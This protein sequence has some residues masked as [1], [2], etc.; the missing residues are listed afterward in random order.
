M[1]NL[2]TKIFTF[3]IALL[4]FTGTG[5]LSQP[6][7]VDHTSVNKYQD[8]PEYYINE[9]KKMWVTIPGESHSVAYRTGCTLL[10]Q[11]DSRFD[12]NI[13]DGGTPESYT[14]QHLRISRATWGD[15][16]HE[17]GWIYEYGEEDWFTS[18]TAIIRTKAGITYCNT[19]D[20]IIS[21]IGLGWCWDAGIS[22]PDYLSATDEY[23][24]YCETMGY[25]A[26]VIFTTGTVENASGEIQ[27]TKH[28]GYESIRD[29]V[30]NSTDH[31]LFDY[32][33]I[34]CYDDDGSVNTATWNNHTYP[35]ITAA[36]LGDASLGHISSAG[37]L[38]LG[39]AIWYMMARIA[40]WNGLPEGDDTEAPTTPSNLQGIALSDTSAQ[41][42]WDVSTDNVGVTGYRIYRNG[43]VMDSTADLT[44]T[45]DG[46]SA[47]NNY[48]YWVTAIDAEGNES[49][50]SDTLII[51]TENTSILSISY[52]LNVFPN[53]SSGT[54]EI[55]IPVNDGQSYFYLHSVEG[56]M[57]DF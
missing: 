14:D 18:E 19:H 29:H 20:L 33:D 45:D 6:I 47:G 38:R 10:E 23:V 28:L 49:T 1:K 54:F 37:A 22:F 46:L 35:L 24:S 39:K 26:K 53:P 5:A 15:V 9:V 21:A 2:V 40:G 55:D 12:V 27:Y 7:I 31:I 42:S 43:T 8:I 41:L 51:S 13:V 57:L 3:L 50:H 32:A 11:I 16:T 44:F 30:K 34:L 25:A 4:S 48:S 17:S 56:I 52:Q 36:N